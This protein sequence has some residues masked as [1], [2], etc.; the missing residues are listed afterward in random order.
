[1]NIYD[2]NGNLIALVVYYRDIKMGK[3]FLTL[4]NEDMQ[5]ATFSFDK[6]SIIENHK[7]N[8]QNRIIESTSEFLLVLDGEMTVEIFDDELNFITSI[9]LKSRDSITLFR[10]GHGVNIHSECKF[11]EAKQGPY[12]EELDKQR[13]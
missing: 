6:Q 5:I 9:I 3:N 10:G 4:G 11:I 7:H 1:M 12:T 2:N 13:F 8:K